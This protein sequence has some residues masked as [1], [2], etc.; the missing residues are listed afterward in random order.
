[1]RVRRKI[2]YDENGKPVEVLISWEDFRK[3]EQTLGLDLEEEVKEHLRNL[4]EETKPEDYVSLE[5]L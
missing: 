4:K 1:M 3:I 5:E 2:V